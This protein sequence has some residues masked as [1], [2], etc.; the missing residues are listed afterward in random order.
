MIPTGGILTGKNSGIKIIEPV[1]S[2]ASEVY[3]GYCSLGD[4]VMTTLRLKVLTSVPGYTR[5]I[6]VPAPKYGA[7]TVYDSD[8][9]NRFQINDSGVFQNVATLEAGDYTVFAIYIK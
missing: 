7:F 4:I 5:Q 1:I 9:A 2:S 3:G 6:S 8:N